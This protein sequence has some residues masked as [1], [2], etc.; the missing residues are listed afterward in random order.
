[1]IADRVQKLNVS[2]IRKV[3]DLAKKL[4][5][6]INFSIGQPHFPV[7]ERVKQA[8]IEAIQAD[9]NSY[10][11]TQ[12]ITPLIEAIEFHNNERSLKYEDLIVTSG[13]SGGLFLAF[14]TL[15]NPGDE[16]LIT[17]PY[18]L[19]Y[20]QLANFL[21]AQSKYIETYPHFKCT[22]E[23]LEPHITS[24]SKVHVLNTPGNPTGVEINKKEI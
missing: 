12:G 24:K 17:D 16:V 5:N 20:K 11:P 15:L 1:M 19:M 8:S 13:V 23:V 18:F 7:P 6:P 3:F 4:E 14:S 9:H 2:G 21:D 22:A 10:T